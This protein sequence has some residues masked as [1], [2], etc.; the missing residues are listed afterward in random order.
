MKKPPTRLTLQG[1]ERSNQRRSKHDTLKAS[2][3]Q[4]VSKSQPEKKY[5]KKENQSYQAA[6][7]KIRGKNHQQNYCTAYPIG[8]GSIRLVKEGYMMKPLSKIAK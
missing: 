5:N 7:N 8:V 4:N 3:H 1:S 6:G 2:R